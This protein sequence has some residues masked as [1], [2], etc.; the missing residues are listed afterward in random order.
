MATKRTE[1]P[2]SGGGG[3]I[4]DLLI[5]LIGLAALVLIVALYASDAPCIM[6]LDSLP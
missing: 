2:I 5:L 1:R 6:P 4:G 3:G